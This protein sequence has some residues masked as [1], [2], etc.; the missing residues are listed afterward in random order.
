MDN[1]MEDV[2]FVR[3]VFNAWGRNEVEVNTAANKPVKEVQFI[4]IEF[5]N[6]IWKFLLNPSY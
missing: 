4:R 2:S 3:M 5:D 6:R 1:E